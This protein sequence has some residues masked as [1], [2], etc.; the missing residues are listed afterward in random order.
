MHPPR[1]AIHLL[2]AGAMCLA[3][4]ALAQ[5]AKPPGH[6]IATID[7]GIGPCS[8]DLT[9]LSADGKP[10]YGAKVNVH[11]AYGFGGFHKLDLEAS[12][13]IDGKVNFKGLPNRVRRPPLEF[14][15]SKDQLEGMAT[16]DPAVEC[17]AKHDITLEKPKPPEDK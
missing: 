2:L 1:N 14:D 12:T 3:S 4:A 13:N 11:I 8:L 10:V 9:V 7:G 17:R 16:Y 5:S 15:A 6:D